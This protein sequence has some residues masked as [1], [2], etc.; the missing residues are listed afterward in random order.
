MKLLSTLLLLIGTL[1]ASAQ[2]DDGWFTGKV[3]GGYKYASFDYI[4]NLENHF[5]AGT[6]YGCFFDGRIFITGALRVRPFGKKTVMPALW[7]NYGYLT[8][9][10]SAVI[11]PK[12]SLE[13]GN[14]APV[15]F[16]FDFGGAFFKGENVWI[17]G[18]AAEF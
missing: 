8:K 4:Y 12:I 15:R 5:S 18:L 7:L 1:T 14:I 16:A 2:S 6:E 11:I 3:S 9:E 13:L 17:L 10:K